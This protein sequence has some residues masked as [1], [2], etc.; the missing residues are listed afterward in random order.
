[1]KEGKEKGSREARKMN[2]ETDKAKKRGKAE[3]RI[4]EKEANSVEKI[5]E[6]ERPM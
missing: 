1:M 3:G 2:K 5:P 4:S 6:S